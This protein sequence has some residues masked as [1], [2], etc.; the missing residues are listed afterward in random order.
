MAQYLRSQTTGVVLPYN[1]KL[2]SRPNI[3]LM[4]SDECNTYDSEV[5]AR[6]AAKA[7]PATAP[8]P[9]PAPELKLET[10]EPKPEPTPD[11]V[12]SEQPVVEP[13]IEVSDISDGEPSAAELLDALELDDA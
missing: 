9:P 5:R 6:L 3:E 13:A 10:G 2:L 7:K 1:E 8:Q 12:V 11:E 4:T